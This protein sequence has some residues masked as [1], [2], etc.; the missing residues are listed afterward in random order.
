MENPPREH[1]TDDATFV[2]AGKGDQF[3]LRGAA[4]FLP[5]V[6]H[7]LHFRPYSDEP[8]LTVCTNVGGYWAEKVPPIA[9]LLQSGGLQQQ[10]HQQQPERFLPFLAFLSVAVFGSSRFSFSGALN[11]QRV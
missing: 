6:S 2:H 8:S 10:H 3:C 4:G 5:G 1:V 11:S 9:L 7:R